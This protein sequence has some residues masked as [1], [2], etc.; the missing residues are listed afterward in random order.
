[1]SRRS[2]TDEQRAEALALYVELGAAET[3]RRTGIAKGTVMSWASRSG[4]A[5]HATEATRKATEASALKWAQRRQQLVH[6]IGAV[7][8]LALRQAQVSVETGHARNAKDFATTMAILVDKAQLLDGAATS[9]TAL[10][11]ERTPE[12]E[13]ELA[14]VLQLRAVA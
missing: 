1:M 2:Y 13:A 5:M 7:A 4:L 8:E 3:A 9:R 14:K 11:G 12:R 10:V 6:D